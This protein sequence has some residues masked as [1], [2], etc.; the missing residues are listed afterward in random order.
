MAEKTEVVVGRVVDDESYDQDGAH[1]SC[2]YDVRPESVYA[3]T[4][5]D[6][7]SAF[8]GLQVRVSIEVVA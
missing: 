5:Q 1:H 7:L 8:E 6:A 3:Q 2:G 4:L